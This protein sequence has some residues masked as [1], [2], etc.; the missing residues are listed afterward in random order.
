M[1]WVLNVFSRAR[2]L[3]SRAPYVE[4]RGFIIDIG[5]SVTFFR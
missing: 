1:F 4:I 5:S 3:G 2:E